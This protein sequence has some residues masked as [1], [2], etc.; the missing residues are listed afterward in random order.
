MLK[1]TLISLNDDWTVEYLEFAPSLYEFME[2]EPVPRLSEWSFDRRRIEG[3]AAWL[4]RS[5]TLPTQ[6]VFQAYLYIDSA[7]EG[8]GIYL[9]HRRVAR[10]IT[11]ADDAPPFE[12]DVSR[13]VRA[14]RNVIAFRV[15][16]LSPSI[17]GVALEIAAHDSV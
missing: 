13:Y 2:R 12:L 14:G 16:G 4:E 8:M 10:Y 5:F 1:P 11:P 9:N 6:R 17:R 15:E 3:W 7:P